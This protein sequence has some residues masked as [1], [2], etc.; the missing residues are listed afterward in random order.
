MFP[1]FR[2]NADLVV[3]TYQMQERQIETIRDEFADFF[4]DKNEFKWLLQSNTQDHQMLVIYQA[5][6]VYSP[7]QAL[8]I[9]HAE[10]EPE[11]FR[12]GRFSFWRDSGCDWEYQ[13]KK[14]L[15][16][17][18]LDK[19]KLEPK[20]EEFWAKDKEEEEKF[21]SEQET[22][23]SKWHINQFGVAPK[24]VQRA[25][26]MEIQKA[27]GKSAVERAEKYKTAGVKYV[28]STAH[29]F[30]PWFPNVPY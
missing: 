10:L 21:R 5:N 18:T 8:F 29:P 26:D 15:S 1:D 11:P 9:S 13:L 23:D 3:C 25:R 20:L 6:A 30:N 2:S 7:E 22:Y 19:A 4:E 12:V 28:P 16:M 27:M 24:T 17:K 14:Y